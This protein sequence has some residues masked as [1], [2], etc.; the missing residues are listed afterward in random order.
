MTPRKSALRKCP[1]CDLTNDGEHKPMTNPKRLLNE[2]T[3]LPC[4]P[5]EEWFDRSICSE[6]CGSMHNRCTDCGAVSDPAR[7]PS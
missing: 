1:E 7:L 3:P 4:G 2:A 6:P 5:A